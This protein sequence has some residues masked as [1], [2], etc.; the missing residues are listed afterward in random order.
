MHAERREYRLVLSNVDRDVSLPHGYPLVLSRHPSE[1]LEHL[2]LRVLAWALLY[3]E[4]LEFGPGLSAGDAP[5]LVATDLTG[6]TA[7]WVAVG[8]ISPEL[9]QRI[10]QHN[11]QAAVHVVFGDPNRREAFLTE[12]A[13]WGARLPRGWDRLSLWS[14]DPKLITALA[15]SGAPRQR[16]TI[17][18]VGDHVYVD[19]GTVV[20]DGAIR[21]G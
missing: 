18:V 20:V 1:T 8:D 15:A 2:T 11:R 7:T 4:R 16:W 17:T 3:E 12:V 5:D 14:F 6:K 9:T 10:L 19:T 21:R 13:S